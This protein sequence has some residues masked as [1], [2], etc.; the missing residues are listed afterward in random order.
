[1]IK[2]I[3]LLP[4]LLLTLVMSPSVSADSDKSDTCS[5]KHAMKKMMNSLQLSSDQQAKIK[6][7]KA[8]ARPVIKDYWKQM[9]QITVQI[10]SMTTSDKV[11][12]ASLDALIKQKTDLYSK[13]MKNRIMTKN[14][15]YHVLTA[16]QQ[17]QY[18][19]LMKQ[20]QSKADA[21]DASCSCTK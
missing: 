5:C 7:I 16:Q 17:Q 11:D 15:I 8:Q 21:K 6:A 12:E 18:Q 14:Q 3:A 13:I 19:E 2:K 20:L 1:M 4:L 9:G 10:N